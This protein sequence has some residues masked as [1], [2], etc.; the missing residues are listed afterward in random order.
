MDA[1][2]VPGVTSSTIAAR[3][4]SLRAAALPF[5]VQEVRA[6][7]VRERV[8]DPEHLP[9]KYQGDFIKRSPA[10]SLL[11]LYDNLHAEEVAFYGWRLV[12]GTFQQIEITVREGREMN[13][14]FL[15]YK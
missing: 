8:E 4:S 12:C 10:E 14:C 13:A 15:E 11:D 7:G 5:D 3:P 9:G 6:G 1:L 2:Q